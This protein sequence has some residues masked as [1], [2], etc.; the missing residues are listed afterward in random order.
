MTFNTIIRKITDNMWVKH[1]FWT[2]VAVMLSLVSANMLSLEEY[3]W[4]PIS[5]IIVMQSSLGQSWDVSKQRLIGTVIGALFAGVFNFVFPDVNTLN[6]SLGIFLLGIICYVF[7]LTLS[8][9]RLGGVTFSIIL[10]MHHS[11]IAWR[12]GLDRFIEVA[13]GI[14]AALIVSAVSAQCPVMKEIRKSIK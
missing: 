10:L 11:E 12:I 6:F 8:A 4:A 5:T 9:Y 3:Y 13:V 7:K 2:A 1:S 14:C